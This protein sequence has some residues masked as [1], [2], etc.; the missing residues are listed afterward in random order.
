[1]DASRRHKTPRS[2]VKD[3]LLLK[4]TAVARISASLCRFPKP[5]FPQGDG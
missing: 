1:M 5:H 2:E 4:E 3:N